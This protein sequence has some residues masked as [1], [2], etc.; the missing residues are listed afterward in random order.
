MIK[1]Q[2][3]SSPG[4]VSRLSVAIGQAAAARRTSVL[5]L[6]DKHTAGLLTILEEA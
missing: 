4:P 5:G 3:N 2:E 6:N 1:P